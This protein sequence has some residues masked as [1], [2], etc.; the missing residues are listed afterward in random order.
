[1]PAIQR[2]NG[3][4][5]SVQIPIPLVLSRFLKKFHPDIVHSHHPFLM[6]DTALRVSSD[7]KIPIVFTYHTRYEKYTH[8]V[9]VKA[10][11]IKRFV[12]EL[13]KGYEAPIG[14]SSLSL[15]A[16]LSHTFRRLFS[17]Y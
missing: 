4:D 11:S 7:Y 5:F 6:G 16:S 1:M 12:M 13:S 2:F 3:T 9:P 8:Y 14:A 10:E 17:K 15:E